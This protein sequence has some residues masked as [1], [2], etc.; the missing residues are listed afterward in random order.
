M[1]WGFGLEPPL[2]GWNK[3]EGEEGVV[4]GQGVRSRLQGPNKRVDSA[5]VPT[6]EEQ[7]GD[8]ARPAP[9]ESTPC[10]VESYCWKR[11]TFSP[12]SRIIADPQ[13]YPTSAS[14]YF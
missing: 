14:V 6:A 1:G 10:S 11:G 2:G 9:R 12:Q 5:R 7:E 4:G 8:G 13:I 3:A